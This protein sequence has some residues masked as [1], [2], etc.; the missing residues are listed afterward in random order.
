M[1]IL[2]SIKTIGFK[3]SVVKFSIADSKKNFGSI[4]WVIKDTLSDKI[5]ENINNLKKGEISKPILL[6][7]GVLILKLEDKKLVDENINLNEEL[8]KNVQ[9]EINN[10]LNNYSIIY[11]NKIKNNTNIYEF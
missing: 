7:S 2:N 10:Q 8:E 1:Q 9:K 4:G 3:E 11:F 6:N 5:K